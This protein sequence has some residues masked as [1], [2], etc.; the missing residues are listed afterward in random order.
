MVLP[1]WYKG[2]N[3]DVL[4]ILCIRQLRN[5]QIRFKNNQ[6]APGEWKV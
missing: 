2:L 6:V 3:F 1:S 5:C 4:H